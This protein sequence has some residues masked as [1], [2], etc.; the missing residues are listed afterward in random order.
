M[1]MRLIVVIEALKVGDKR[2]TSSKNS[3]ARNNKGRL[4]AQSPFLT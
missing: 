2:E 4:I 3:R 1:E